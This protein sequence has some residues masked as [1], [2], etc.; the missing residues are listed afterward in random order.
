MIFH[1]CSG[2]FIPS[3]PAVII[4][5]GVGAVSWRYISLS[6]RRILTRVRK[7][8]YLEWWERKKT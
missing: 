8:D 5:G 7:S 3:A 6:V 4:L 2:V 1:V